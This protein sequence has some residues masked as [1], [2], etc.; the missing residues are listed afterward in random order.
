[1]LH[2]RQRDGS[3]QLGQAPGL[4]HWSYLDCLPYY[5]KAETRDIGANDYHGGDGPVSVTTPKQGNNPLFQA[6]V[7]AGVQP[8]IRAPTISTATSRKGLARWIAP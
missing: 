4:E 3:R 1:V 2:P 5:R 7:E 6:M 8:A